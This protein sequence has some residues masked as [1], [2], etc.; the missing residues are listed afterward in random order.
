MALLS[1][2]VPIFLFYNNHLLCLWT[3]LLFPGLVL[4]EKLLQSFQSIA[5]Y[6]YIFSD[7]V[8]NLCCQSLLCFSLIF[9]AVLFTCLPYLSVIEYYPTLYVTCEPAATDDKPSNYQA[10]I[11]NLR[12]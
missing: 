2:F 11:S 7:Q 3:Y 9:A 12:R 4:F 5:R 1:L 6:M 10:Q 8:I